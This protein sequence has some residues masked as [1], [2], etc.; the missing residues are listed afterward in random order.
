[1]KVQSRPCVHRAIAHRGAIAAPSFRISKFVRCSVCHASSEKQATEPGTGGARKLEEGRMTYNP[2]TFDE[3]IS[4]ASVAV[5]RGLDSGLTRMEVEFPVV[6]GTDCALF[7]T[8]GSSKPGSHRCQ[9]SAVARSVAA[10][11][12]VLNCPI[13][14]ICS[15]W[16]YVPASACSASTLVLNKTPQPAL[17]SGRMYFTRRTPFCT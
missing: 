6:S 2:S 10:D 17:L 5:C 4:D 15:R 12:S 9:A 3:M 14:W 11:S 16:P 8:S 13:Y 1:M 7:S